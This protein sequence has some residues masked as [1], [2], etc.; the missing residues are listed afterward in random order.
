VFM[1]GR[2]NFH[3]TDLERKRLKT[4]IEKGGMLLA[5][6]IC[7]S[8]AFTE[9]FRREMAEVFPDKKL[10]PIP[11]ND[12]LLTKTYGGSDLHEVSRHEPSSETGAGKRLESTPPKKGPPELE[13]IKFGDR[14][15]IVFSPFDL[16][17]AL[18]KQ[19]SLQCRGYVRDDAAKIGL[20]VVLYSLQQ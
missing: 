4:Y 20:N 7:A 16:S 8:R 17:C 19:D 3:L 18:E 9:S 13:G 11:V 12:P 2:T 15:G 1:H 14:W 10:E 6:S 5:D